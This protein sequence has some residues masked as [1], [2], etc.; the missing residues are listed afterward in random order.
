[1]S[2]EN[3][4]PNLVAEANRLTKE[5]LLQASSPTP[6]ASTYNRCIEALGRVQEKSRRGALEAA[7]EEVETFL[8]IDKYKYPGNIP[9]VIRDLIKTKGE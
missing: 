3:Y 6:E 1:M 7:A 4:T 2:N 5:V 9:S 8:R